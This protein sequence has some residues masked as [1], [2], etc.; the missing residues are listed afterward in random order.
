MKDYLS[1]EEVAEEL[2]VVNDTV[3]SWLKLGLLRGYKL[4][5]PWRIKRND[6]DQF[7]SERSN[8]D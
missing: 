2:G 7:M 4:G 8:I 5:R 1:V 3:R 6:L